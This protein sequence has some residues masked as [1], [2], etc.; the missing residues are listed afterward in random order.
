MTADA[1]ERH[2]NVKATDYSNQVLQPLMARCDWARAYGTTAQYRE[3]V[4][5]LKT[6]ITALGTDSTFEKEWEERECDAIENPTD[7]L[8]PMFVSPNAGQVSAWE[9]IV[10]DLGRRLGVLGWQSRNSMARL[11]QDP[12]SAQQSQAPSNGPATDP[13]VGVGVPRDPLLAVPRPDGPVAPLTEPGPSQAAL[14][15][16]RLRVA[17]SIQ[18]GQPN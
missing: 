15:H 3:C 11:G 1:T 9:T 4:L 2:V 14:F 12:G 5:A 18:N 8:H 13:G 16:Q 7:P 10:L 17:R 6:K